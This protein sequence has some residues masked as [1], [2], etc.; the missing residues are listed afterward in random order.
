MRRA[1]HCGLGHTAPN[2]V[3][4]TLEKFPQIYQQRLAQSNYMPAFDLDAALAEARRLSGRDDP[5]AHIAHK[6]A[7]AT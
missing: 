1:S 7:A 4:Q 6:S 3:L 2:H 5:A